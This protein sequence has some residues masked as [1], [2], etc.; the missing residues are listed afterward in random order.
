MS[1]KSNPIIKLHDKP[2]EYHDGY[3][4]DAELKFDENG[5]LY[6]NAK[7]IVLKYKT[8]KEVFAS[9]SFDQDLTLLNPSTRKLRKVLGIKTHWIWGWGIK[10]EL[11]DKI[12]ES[13][14]AIK[15]QSSYYK[16]LIWFYPGNDHDQTTSFVFIDKS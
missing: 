9:Y 7:K 1:D 2:N 12:L 13:S 16:G 8:A 14:G 15:Y 4:Q 3:Y 11:V 6:I 10:K 5:I